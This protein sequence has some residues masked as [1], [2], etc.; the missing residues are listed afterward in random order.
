M[1]KSK[2]TFISSAI[3]AFSAS[4]LPIA[5]AAA[6]CSSDLSNMTCEIRGGGQYS[7]AGVFTGVGFENSFGVT[8]EN[9]DS[10]SLTNTG[11]INAPYSGINI[12]GTPFTINPVPSN[13][14]EIYNSG[15]ISADSFGSGAAVRL[16]EGSTLE[17]LV[18]LGTIEGAEG[19]L[20]VQGNL[21]T[22]K[23]YQGG[24][25]AAL[26][27]RSYYGFGENNLP[28]TYIAVVQDVSEYGQVNFVDLVA[29]ETQMNFVA[30]GF[31]GGSIPAGRY[32]NVMTFSQGRT[33]NFNIPQGVNYSLE[34]TDGGSS[35][36][37]VVIAPAVPQDYICYLRC[38]H[39]HLDCCGHGF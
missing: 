10:A 12:G 20:Q 3:A 24:A 37:L 17:S 22:L 15:V 23:N 31:N 7:F 1:S 9:S 34:T 28:S 19:G 21:G 16:Y 32:P 5:A 39:R 35:W 8:F 29:P 27:Y 38:Q 2:H 18:N 25:S 4:I 26:E 14:S 33:A 6:D 36:D 11:N 30:E 13:V